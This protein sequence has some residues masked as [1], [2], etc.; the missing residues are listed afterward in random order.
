MGDSHSYDRIS[1]HQALG[2]GSGPLLSLKILARTK[3]FF[4][5]IHR[6]LS[7]HTISKHDFDS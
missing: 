2:G 7:V 4:K 5:Y 1:V 6:Y 3:F